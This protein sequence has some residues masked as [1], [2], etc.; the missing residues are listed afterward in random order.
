MAEDEIKTKDRIN[1]LISH[2]PN[3]D[4]HKY[5]GTC[6]TDMQLIDSEPPIDAEGWEVL[7]HP[8]Y[9]SSLIYNS[10]S[11]FINEI[12]KLILISFPDSEVEILF[13][14]CFLYTKKANLKDNDSLKDKCLKIANYIC[15]RLCDKIEK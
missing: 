8:N 13:K 1:K 9:Y 14:E 2:F 4:T 12:Q 10:A 7:T 6:T 11:V 3:V 15:S 5:T